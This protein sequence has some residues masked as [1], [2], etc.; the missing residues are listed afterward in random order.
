MTEAFCGETA[1]GVEWDRPPS[2]KRQ[3]IAEEFSTENGVT[4]AKGID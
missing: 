3:Q 1:D 4:S 2:P